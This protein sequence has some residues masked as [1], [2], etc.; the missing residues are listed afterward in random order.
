MGEVLDFFIH[1][2]WVVMHQQNILVF[3]TKRLSNSVSSTTDM[4][5]HVSATYR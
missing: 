5:L 3:K 2:K 1:M 4:F